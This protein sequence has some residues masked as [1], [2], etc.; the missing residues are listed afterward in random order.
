M[1]MK[2]LLL[3]LL[4]ILFATSSWAQNQIAS[5]SADPSGLSFNL[6]TDKDRYVLGEPVIVTLSW[7]NATD[8]DFEVMTTTMMD[9]VSVYN[10]EAK[11]DLPYRGMIACGSAGFKNIAAQEKFELRNVINDFLFPNFDL[12]KPGRYQVKSTYS[13]SDFEKRKNFWTGQI[14]SAATFDI[15]RLD[16]LSLNREREKAIAGN[17]LALQILAAH[18]D[19]VIVSS[20]AELIKSSDKETRERVYRTLLIL[21]TENTIRMLA[22]AATANIPPQEKLS[23]LVS[24]HDIKP[25]PN[26]VVIS[27][28]EK[29]LDDSYVGGYSTTQ[30]EGEAPRKYKQYT[31]RKWAYFV[32]KKLNIETQ[33]VYEEEMKEDQVTTNPQ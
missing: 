3:A 4:F 11:K 8:K 9:A 26:A 1:N 23:I 16:E 6:R 10:E 18:G 12:T 33:V 28:M 24:L 17:K 5:E 15:I 21:N 19:E 27:Y 32:L 31:V 30:N 20:L 22:E 13:S 2:S 25:T 7:Q 29:L 14:S